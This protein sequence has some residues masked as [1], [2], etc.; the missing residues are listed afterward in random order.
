MKLSHSE[1]LAVSLRIPFLRRVLL[2]WW[3]YCVWLALLVG[4]LRI[5]PTFRFLNNQHQTQSD[6]NGKLFRTNYSKKQVTPCNSRVSGNEMTLQ[7]V[8]KR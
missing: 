7:V 3:Q 5:F 1:D 6:L 8:R 2:I 4:R